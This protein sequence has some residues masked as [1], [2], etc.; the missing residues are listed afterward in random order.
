LRTSS[1]CDILYLK[2]KQKT[3]RVFR[4]NNKIIFILS[5]IYIVLSLLA[6]G[7][8]FYGNMISV[9]RNQINGDIVASASKS[10]EQFNEKIN[11]QVPDSPPSEI[12]IA[13]EIIEE[14]IPEKKEEVVTPLPQPQV[15]NPPQNPVQNPA[16]SPTQPAYSYTA[17]DCDSG[18]AG[19]MLNLVNEH[20]RANAVAE[21]TLVSDL[22]GVS[23]A[24][25]KWMKE[26]G[27]FSHEGY[28]GT[29]FN[30]RCSRAGTSCNAENIAFNSSATAQKMF[31]QFK[32]SQGH[33][34]N[35]LNPNFTS[36]GIGYKDGYVTQTFR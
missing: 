4:F 30:V 15:S 2:Q 29:K 27:K 14:K 24:H 35:M 25:S 34:N 10:I 1:F 12:A 28:D 13:D 31:D 36:I 3:N 6:G 19:T 9:T 18:F 7:M 33:N 23:C 22:S 8:W 17:S 21:L 32:N 11:L 16:P 26:T 5:A 20:R